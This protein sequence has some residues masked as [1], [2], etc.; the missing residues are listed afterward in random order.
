MSEP[1]LPGSRCSHRRALTN[2]NCA[3]NLAQRTYPVGVRPLHY[4][5]SE[6]IAACEQFLAPAKAARACGQ[7]FSELTNRSLSAA[8]QAR[9][10]NAK[11]RPR[12]GRW[13]RPRFG[14][15]MWGERRNVNESSSLIVYVCSDPEARP[16]CRR[17]GR[18]IRNCVGLNGEVITP[19]VGA[20]VAVCRAW[21][22]FVARPEK[23]LQKNAHDPTS[24]RDSWGCRATRLACL[25]AAGLVSPH[26]PPRCGGYGRRSAARI[27]LAARCRRQQPA[28]RSSRCRRCGW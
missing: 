18:A 10:A 24:L 12:H 4:S 13:T 26:P 3:V 14:G 23:G 20:Q 7:G 21:N 17:L 6:F 11:P 15:G 1:A 25:G 19:P 5:W 22:P 27:F 9:T 8:R 16:V 28:S 2:G